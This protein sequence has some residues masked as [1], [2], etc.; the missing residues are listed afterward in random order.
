MNK[1][2]MSILFFAVCGILISV[3]GCGSTNNPVTPPTTIT[4]S[5]K[6]LDAYGYPLGSA[7]TVLIGTQTATT[8]AD[9]SFTINN[10]STTYDVYVMNVNGVFGV[11]GL[12]ISSPYLPGSIMVPV[13]NGSIGVTVPIVPAGS[14]VTAIFQDTVTGKVSGYGQITAGQTIGSVSIS[15]TNGQPVAGKLYIIQYIIS[16]GVAGTYTGYAEQ[17]V[18][19]NFGA[20]PNYQFTS[21]SGG[22]GTQTVSGTVNGA[23][24]TNLE[25]QLYLNFGSKNN[26]VHR[27]GFVQ[28]I[29]M[30]GNTGTFTF[31][32]PTNTTSTS[33]INVIALSTL[34]TTTL[35]MKTLSAGTSGAVINIDTAATLLTPTNGTANVDTTTNF[36]FT[37]GGGNGVHF[38]RL[39]PNPNGKFFQIITKGTSLTIP[40]LSA[41]GYILGSSNVYNWNEIKSMDVNSTN[42]FCAQFFD[43]NPA[44]L[45]TT[46]SS[47]F[48]FTA[49]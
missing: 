1:I 47:S 6:V 46:V 9:G 30:T 4:V 29:I 48:T 10:V 3:Y 38:I 17:S 49:R 23:G 45:G 27:G 8:A 40:N 35:R 25:A 36:S 16:G 31:N 43:L 33:Q 20:N 37:N 7:S 28:T 19:F 39:T 18:S 5:G 12:T 11:K 32:V 2:K 24:G 14:K 44:T 22:L 34:P 21:Y 15:G 42:D 13:S 41:Y 26:I